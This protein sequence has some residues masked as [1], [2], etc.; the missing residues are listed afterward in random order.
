[1]SLG[2]ESSSVQRPFVRYAVAA[3]W[4]Y[5][6]P[7]D[8]LVLRQGGFTSPVLDA[9]LTPQLVKLNPKVLDAAKAGEVIKRLVRVR[10]SIEGN[11]DAWEF[12]KG[13]K[14]VF[15]EAEKRERNV[16]FMDVANPG[17]NVFHV[18]E[19]FTFSS[20]VAPDLR[21]DLGFFINGVPVLIIETKKATAMDGIA[22]ALDDIRYY[23]RKGPEFLALNQLH[24]LTHLIQ[25]Y[26]G[27]TWNTS[28]KAQKPDTVKV[29][30]LLKAL[31]QLVRQN[32]GKEPYLI[33]I[34]DR[35]AEIAAA[36]E[37]RQVRMSIFKALIDTGVEAVAEVADKL[38]RL[39]RR[40]RP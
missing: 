29:F 11:L 9:V 26:Y 40:T 28:A 18:T 14:T 8:A 7:D 6:S 24:A 27:A 19:E 37:D 1:M 10:P 32:A 34:G 5:L 23:H 20:G 4:T 39:L 30:N 22:Q 17:V 33:S 3:G 36:F 38:M 31:D 25:F 12:L 13:L 16:R 15:V 21:A 2:S 35:A